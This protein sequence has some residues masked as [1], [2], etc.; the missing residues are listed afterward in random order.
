M[1]FKRKPTT[2]SASSLS[3]GRYDWARVDLGG[4]GE[5]RKPN[6]AEAGRPKVIDLGGKNRMRSREDR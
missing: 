4:L 1:S 5:I 3:E 2:A 6:R